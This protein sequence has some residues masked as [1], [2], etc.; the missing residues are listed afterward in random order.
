MHCLYCASEDT[1]VVDKRDN[2][3]I[4]RRRRECL[5]CGRRFTTYERPEFSLIVIKKDG[6]REGFD[7]EKL[8]AG[9]TKACKNRP[10]TPEQIEGAVEDMEARLKSVG[11]EIASQVIG[12]LVMKKLKKLDDVAYIRFASVYRNFASAREFEREVKAIRR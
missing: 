4:T 8:K 1:K 2:E 5:K 7:R 3:G 10:V 6:S 9:I 11:S 12:E